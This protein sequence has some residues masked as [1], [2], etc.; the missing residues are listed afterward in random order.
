MF[1]LQSM[2][3]DRACTIMTKEEI[4]T[5]FVKVRVELNIIHGI[6]YL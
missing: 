1:L 3:N 4:C 6:K 5:G 2:F